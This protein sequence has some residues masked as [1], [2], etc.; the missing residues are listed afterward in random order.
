MTSFPP[1]KIFRET[2]RHTRRIGSHWNLTNDLE[3]FHPANPTIRPEG[4]A[5]SLSG[6]VAGA[7]ASLQQ[8]CQRSLG[9]LAPQIPSIR[10]KAC[11]FKNRELPHGE[12]LMTEVS[13]ELYFVFSWKKANFGG[14]KKGK[15]GE[16]DFVVEL[17]KK[18]IEQWKKHWLFRWYRGLYYP[19]I[20]RL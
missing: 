2:Y 12:L 13:C 6:G 9:S 11:V 5:P 18:P 15:G 1:A 10:W 20:W 3:N 4:L 8:H 7:A 19:V 17:I 16:D 14:N